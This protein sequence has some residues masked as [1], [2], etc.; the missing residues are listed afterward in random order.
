VSLL[1][2]SERLT[3]WVGAI[4]LGVFG[5]AI[6]FF[7]VI[8]DQIE[9]GSH[10]RVRVYFRQTGGL[11]EGSTFVVAGRTVGRVEAIALVP[12]G[13]SRILGNDEGVALTVAIDRG[14]ADKL[15]VDGDVFVA[16]RGP[17]S[18]KYLELA[19]PREPG[20]PL[21]EGAELR[22]ADPPSLDRVLQRTWDNLV[23]AR[24]FA[25]E[26][27]PEMT[28]LRAQ[29]VL[30]R[31]NLAELAPDVPLG[32]DVDA[33]VAE[34]RVTWNGSLGGR[35]GVDRIG[36]VIDE[37]RA[38]VAQGRAMLTALDGKAQALRASL[39]T[40]R[41]TLGAKGEVIVDK[42]ELAID[43]T[44]AAIDKLDPLL[45]E[46][47]ALQ[48]RIARG[49]GSLLKLMNDPEFPE[50]AKELGKILKRQPWRVIDHP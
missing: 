50:D 6:V 40:A 10:V 12:R 21:F 43:R 4:A 15:T 28:E 14:V 11:H 46:V 17:L 36:N 19:P 18:D 33:L 22:G 20:A 45:A 9:W 48:A 47:A 27:R 16:S 25:D 5:F 29:I 13:S 3:R 38:T 24:T 35:A 26:L 37:G 7:V 34:A 49:E 1:A 41:G 44:R 42:V 23:T 31:A 8:Y 2:Q 30:L 32:A 39:V